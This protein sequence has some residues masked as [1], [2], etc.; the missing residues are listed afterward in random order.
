M[1]SYTNRFHNCRA[2]A[3]DLIHELLI[4]DARCQEDAVGKDENLQPAA[5]VAQYQIDY[6][7]ERARDATVVPTRSCGPATP[8]DH[9]ES[10]DAYERFLQNG[11]T[12]ATRQGLP[13]E[14]C[15]DMML[16]LA[17]LALS[18]ANDALGQARKAYEQ[19]GRGDR[20]VLGEL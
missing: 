1:A 7:L 17:E 18:H 16:G 13:A 19:E 4:L 15:L 3:L 2:K 8:R 5:V 20:L 6:A 12:I 9:I 14:L 10:R 11:E